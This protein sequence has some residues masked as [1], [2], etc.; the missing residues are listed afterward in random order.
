MLRWLMI[1]GERESMLAPALREAAAQ[2]AQ[3]AAI[4]AELVQKLVPMALVG[5]VGG[6]ITLVYALTVFVPLTS[7]W[8]GLAAAG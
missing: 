4:R 1:R 8:R 5:L 7:I 6:G 3:R 2:Y